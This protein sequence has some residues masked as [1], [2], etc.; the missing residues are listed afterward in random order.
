MTVERILPVNSWRK[1]FAIFARAYERLDHFGLLKVSVELIQLLQP[2]VVTGIVRVLSFVR[3]AAQ[4]SKVFHQHE[5]AIEFRVVEFLILG[6]LSQRLR[7]CSDV[8]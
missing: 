6:D 7:A 1:P 4:V 2:K 8:T 5:G 3:I